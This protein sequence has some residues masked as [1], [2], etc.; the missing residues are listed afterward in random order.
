MSHSDDSN[1]DPKPLDPKDDEEVAR[2][3]SSAIE[4]IIQDFPEPWEIKIEIYHPQADV[5][6]EMV[7]G[8]NPEDGFTLDPNANDNS[9]DLPS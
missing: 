7:Y 6:F 1:D 3:V 5:G 9:K 4:K 8:L 2:R